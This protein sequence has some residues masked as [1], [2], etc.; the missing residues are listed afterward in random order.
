MVDKKNSEIPE[1]EQKTEENKPAEEANK[2]DSP[3]DW[4]V[5]T[6]QV[7]YEDPLLSCISIVTRLLEHPLS[8]QVLKAGL[9]FADTRFSPE[10]CVRAAQ[11][12]G[13]N[14]KIVKRPDLLKISNLTLPCILLLKRSNACVLLGVNRRAG[15][16]EIAVAEADGGTMTVPLK[17]IIGSY[18]GHAIFMR[19][20]FKFDARADYDE[21]KYVDSWFWGTL[22]RFL[23]VY[24]HV[25]LASFLIN[26]FALASPLF[27]M[28]VYDRVVPNAAME[29]LW[30]LA[31]G[32]LIVYVFEF[33]LRNLRSYFIDVA[34]KNAD[35]II[36]SQLLE[37]VM[38]MRLDQKPEST[39]AMASNLREFEGLRDFFT[40]STV[41]LLID[42]PF[43]FLFL[44]VIGMLAGWLA[45]IPLITVPIV[46][47]VGWFLQIPLKRIIEKTHAESNQK[48]A[49][50]IETING[51]ETIKTSGAQSRIQG[52]W[53]RAVGMT[54][55]STGKAR[56]I[57]SL[58]TTFS[59][60]AVQ[61][62][63]VVA[64][65]VGVSM[66][67]N[68]NL[69]MG[70][71]VAVSILTGRALAPL[72]SIAGLITRYQQSKVSLDALDKIMKAPVERPKGKTFH[73]VPE[74]QGQ[75]QFQNVSFSYPGQ[76]EKALDDVSFS[77]RPG[78]RVAILG[79]IGS[80]KSTL[81]RLITQLYTPQ[82]GSILIDGIELGQIDPV[83]I[84]RNI[85]YISQDNYLFYGTIRE[86]IAFGAAHVDDN[87]ISVAAHFAGVMDFVRGHSSGLDLQVGERGMALSGG[88]RQSISIARALVRN[89]AILIMDEPT[90]N[91][92]NTSEQRFQ[93][94]LS[95][96]KGLK[97]M[98][99]I[100]HRTS[101]LGLVDRII[102]L[103][104]GKIVA[105]G[106]KDLVLK[107][108][109]GGNA[110]E[111]SQKKPVKKPVKKA[112]KLKSDE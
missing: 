57:S 63:T 104:N 21:S 40:S 92:D 30:V 105:D 60:F 9:P 77:I 111:A 95:H 27:I 39:G 26:L 33:V 31:I 4:L 24:S 97:N 101:L 23:P 12:S 22:K 28:N 69:T 1:K 78:E 83:D 75:I 86:N 44:G 42:F 47:L 6:S 10:L 59:Q 18:T 8:R 41:V 56:M 34:G 19:P 61:T 67:V 82:E 54:A 102:V 89:P 58:A 106:P 43:I 53:E 112:K 11:R 100:T 64:V 80:G 25:L 108:L 68:N 84:R 49:M 91:M 88:Q 79:R 81:G 93:Q 16:A 29:T 15:T 94:R 109:G 45:F 51:L 20:K 72:G 37:Q 55:E 32:V 66:I 7:D 74:F 62:T 35:V 76:Q 87:A 96:Y 107:K 103:E 65:L 13:F 110:V 52:R 17:K 73:H 90:S 48:H 70:A 71:L 2:S 50:L 99:C 98:I 85:G 3:N 5:R 36:A 38:S 46:I 14:A